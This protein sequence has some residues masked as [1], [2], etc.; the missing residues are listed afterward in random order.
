[1]EEEQQPEPQALPLVGSVV[2]KCLA[3]ST[4]E[5]IKAHSSKHLQSNQDMAVS[6]RVLRWHVSAA[7]TLV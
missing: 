7:T 3:Q 1:M 4:H 5:S 2:G 6:T